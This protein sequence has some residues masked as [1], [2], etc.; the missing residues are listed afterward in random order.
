MAN[1]LGSNQFQNEPQYGDVSRLTQLSREA[2]IS[3]APLPGSATNNAP[4]APGAPAPM[5]PGPGALPFINPPEGVAY[6]TRL[7]KTWQ[8][9]AR[10]PGASDTIKQHA[11]DSRAYAKK[12]LEGQV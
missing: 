12:Y 8:A 7:A 10:M 1:P 6:Y 9:L 11:T 4:V 3:G 2:P 5:P